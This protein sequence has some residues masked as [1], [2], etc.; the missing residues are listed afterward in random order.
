MSCLNR[1]TAVVIAGMVCA[2]LLFTGC[3]KKKQ[4]KVESRAVR[5]S[6]QK[7][8]KRVFKRQIPVQGTVE[9]TA[10]AVISA[11]IGGTV[12]MFK[13]GSGDTVK[14]GDV[15]FGIDRK[16]LKN[17]VTMREDEIKVKEAEL[18]SARAEK[19]STVLSEKK[20]V[21]DFNRA[22]KLLKS[23]AISQSE[24]DAYETDYKKAKTD[25]LSAVAAIA[26]AEAQLKQAQS[27]LTIARK[28]LDDSVQ[29]APYD[30]VITATYV[31]ENEYVSG[32]QKMLY[33]EDQSKLEV[34]CYISSV[35]YH[36]IT[37]G[38]TPVEIFLNDAKVSDAVITYKAPSIDP[39][40]RTFEIKALIPKTAKLVSGTLCNV[41]IILESRVGYGL[42]SDAILLR[43]NNRHIVFALG[44]NSI[45]KSF[46]VVPGIVDS[47]YT[48][49]LKT[50]KMQ[51]E[52][53]VVVGQN[54]VN[55]G[56]LLQVI[57]HKSAEDKRC[58]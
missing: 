32:G 37:V 50:D 49:I 13:V 56:A 16:V 7:L 54:F 4:K 31:E 6:V 39:S 23:R 41:N 8:Q 29:R 5:V 51:N 9:P 21:L 25:T 43:A 44:E 3:S 48:E 1:G 10:H 40:S 47:G 33:I 11:K 22:Q 38:K 46:D 24:F 17:Q 57:N 19:E 34:V 18:A 35:Y 52:E 20:A 12:E 58:F 55:P 42:P 28:N 30:G 14:K 15:L 27:N 2:S 45:A 36:D 53:F 26:N